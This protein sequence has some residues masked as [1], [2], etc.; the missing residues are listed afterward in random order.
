MKIG[1]K[2]KIKVLVIIYKASMFLVFGNAIL[3]YFHID[4]TLQKQY[5]FINFAML[6][7]HICKKLK[8]RFN[9]FCRFMHLETLKNTHLAYFLR[10]M[11]QPTYQP[12]AE[13]P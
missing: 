3:A 5:S 8:P 1:N 4:F 13:H 11:N 2:I 9:V 6:L 12:S 10:L 7:E